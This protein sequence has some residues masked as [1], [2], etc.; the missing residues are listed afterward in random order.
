MSVKTYDDRVVVRW[1]V[2]N[3]HKKK[4][5]TAKHEPNPRRRKALAEAYLRE[6]VRE[7]ELGLPQLANARITLREVVVDGFVPTVVNQ[8]E[9]K[10]QALYK[11]LWN[12]HLSPAFGG[13]PIS[14]ISAGMIEEW[15]A[16]SP[17]G[18]VTKRKALVL[19]G[20]IFKHAMKRQYVLHNPV[21]LVDKPKAP[22]KEPVIPPTPL[23]VE[24]IRKTFLDA[25][26]PMEA[27]LV[28]V[29]AYAGLRP[30]GEALSLTRGDV[31]DKTL[32]VRA[33]KTNSFRSVGILPP[34]AEDLR[35]WLGQRLAFDK[36]PLFPNYRGGAWTQTN[37]DNF[38]PRVWNVLLDR[39]EDGKVVRGHSPK[40]LRHTFVS[41]L[42][43][44]ESYSRREIA[45]QAG[46]SLKV[47][48]DNYSHVFAELRGTG[49]A[50]EAI[51]E[52]RAEV[53]G[54]D[55]PAQTARVAGA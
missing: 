20:Q 19:L 16:R 48:D 22:A 1:R 28:S 37:Y 34:L 32:L 35:W 9:P 42:M 45:D 7:R 41:L 2:G 5:F 29:M 23:E 46:H 36:A 33:P 11:S 17:V 43:R 24:R 8:K 55:A 26:R 13:Y 21:E 18:V 3:V 52:A 6:R 44:D 38:V 47:Q 30:L 27:T 50:E 53:F 15:L 14:Q 12:A 39:V 51:R 10:T 40:A 31:R 49:S 4:T 25:G 54:T